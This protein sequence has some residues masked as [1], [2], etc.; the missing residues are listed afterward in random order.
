M[1]HAAAVPSQLKDEMSVGTYSPQ[2]D[3]WC[4]SLQPTPL[5]RL[6]IDRAMVLFY[7]ILSP[8]VPHHTPRRQIQ[9]VIIPN[10]MAVRKYAFSIAN[11]RPLSCP[12]QL[13]AN[14]HGSAPYSPK[15]Q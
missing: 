7:T 15:R 14:G 2:R 11:F 4:Y 5:V 8:L 6:V 13:E 10:K 12:Y 3:Q 1:I 9:V